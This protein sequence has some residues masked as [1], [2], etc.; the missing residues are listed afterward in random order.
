MGIISK[1]G[2]PITA[3]RAQ[4]KPQRIRQGGG[5]MA[6]AS[7]I[8]APPA[9]FQNPRGAA[10]FQRNRTNENFAADQVQGSSAGGTRPRAATAA[11]PR[12]QVMSHEQVLRGAG[13]DKKPNLAQ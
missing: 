12:S 4:N 9:P 7:Q 2:K 10:N 3:A 5:G 11:A 8:A 13:Y 6:A 1:F